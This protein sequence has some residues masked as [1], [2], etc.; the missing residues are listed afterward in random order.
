MPLI[1]KF[2]F[3]SFDQ[4]NN[5]LVTILS[6]QNRVWAYIFFSGFIAIFLNPQQTKYFGGLAMSFKQAGLFTK[7]KTAE[8]FVYIFSFL[9]IFFFFRFSLFCAKHLM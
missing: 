2:L 1:S 7:Y 8:N 9:L 6:I 5:Q 3:K 4:F